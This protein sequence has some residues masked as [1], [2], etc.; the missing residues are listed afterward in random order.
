MTK[1]RTSPGMYTQLLCTGQKKILCHLTDNPFTF[2][3]LIF[4]PQTTMTMTKVFLIPALVLCFALSAFSQKAPVYTNSQGA[5]QGYDPVAYFKEGKPVKG[6]KEL[7]Y[8]WQGANWHFANQENLMAFQAAP[9]KFAPQYGGYCAY[10]MAEG[11]KAPTDPQA[12]T[13]V[14]GKLYL[15]YDPKVRELWN[16]KQPEYIKTADRNWPEVS[17]QE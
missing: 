17:K 14:E 2:E 16:K 10:G 8:A 3:V 4:G 12:W 6:K 15:N 1:P 5:I 11:H 7:S 13:L 9:E